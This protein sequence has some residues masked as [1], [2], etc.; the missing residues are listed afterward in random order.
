VTQEELTLWIH[1]SLN[2]F[3]NQADFG[4]PRRLFMQGREKEAETEDEIQIIIKNM[5]FPRIGTKNEIYCIINLEAIV[6]TRRVDSDIYYHQRVK[7]RA[8]SILNQ[9]IPIYKIGDPKYN[10]ARVGLLRPV[11][12][13]TLGIGSL[14]SEEPFLS[15]ITVVLE[16]HSC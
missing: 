11:P 7:A 9:E 1:A 14:S 10:K 13:Q 16:F 5:N 15:R 4:V 3:I 12:S 2:K 6:K 8:G